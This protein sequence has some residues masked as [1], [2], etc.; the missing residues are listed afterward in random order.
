MMVFIEGKFWLQSWKSEEETK[1]QKDL[2][3]NLREEAKKMDQT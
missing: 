1:E 2:I 3:E